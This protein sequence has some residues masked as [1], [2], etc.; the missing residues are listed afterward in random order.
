MVSATSG[1]VA[2]TLSAAWMWAWSSRG[3]VREHRPVRGVEVDGGDAE[4]GRV[5]RRLRGRPGGVNETADVGARHPHGVE[6]AEIDPLDPRPERRR[7]H[8]AP[9]VHD[10]WIS[11]RQIA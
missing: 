10:A 4:A 1:R 8:P 9:R 3:R 11:G 5:L 2:P 6:A 7:R